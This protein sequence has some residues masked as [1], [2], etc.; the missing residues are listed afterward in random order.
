MAGDYIYEDGRHQFDT[1]AERGTFESQ[2]QTT[3]TGLSVRMRI[4]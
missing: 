4:R 3:S 2:I 1:A